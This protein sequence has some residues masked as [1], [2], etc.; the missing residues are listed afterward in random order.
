MKKIIT[1]A[2][3]LLTVAA[4]AQGTAKKSVP[5]TVAVPEQAEYVPEIARAAIENKMQQI[6]NINGMSATGD[7]GQFFLTC[8]LNVTDKQVV[9]GAPV[10]IAQKID[11]TFYVADAFNKRV[12]ETATISTRGVG[13]GENKAL[14][15]A[16]KQIAPSQPALKAL[17]TNANTKI[18]SYYEAQCDN[19]LQKARTLATARQYE[20]AFFQLSLVPEECSC[21]GKILT[22]ADEL[23]RQYIDYRAQANL[24]KARSIWSAG[25]NREA[26]AEASEYLAQILPDAKCY[27]QALDLQKEIKARIGS[28]I[29]FER[30]QLEWEQQN[31]SNIIK[32]WRDIGVAYGNNQK[33]TTYSPTWV[34]R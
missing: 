16:L 26:A 28:D 6:V 29:D 4:V 8:A 18:I 24:A 19:I 14:I 32:G 13:E 21:Y 17:I 31:V 27:P 7:T 10:K 5:L 12:F 15:A 25:L 23:F 3:C 2:A 30:K 1:F 22:A 33:E 20:E 34:V 11:I 9:A